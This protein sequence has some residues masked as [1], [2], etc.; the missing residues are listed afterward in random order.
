MLNLNVCGP[1]TV[2]AIIGDRSMNSPRCDHQQLNYYSTSVLNLPI[3][4]SRPKSS[5]Y[6]VGGLGMTIDALADW[7]V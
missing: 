5:K 3:K 6:F 4:F 1:V 7:I 2:S